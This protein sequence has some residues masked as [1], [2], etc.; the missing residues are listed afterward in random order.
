MLSDR[1]ILSAALLTIGYVF[2]LSHTTKQSLTITT[3]QLLRF[4]SYNGARIISL[5]GFCI[6]SSIVFSVYTSIKA[7]L[8]ST[9]TYQFDSIFYELDT[10]IH[11]GVKPWEITHKIFSHPL[12]TLFIN[13]L[14][15]L[16]FLLVFLG[17]IWIYLR[18]DSCR[19][20]FLAT[21]LMT[22]VVGGGVYAVLTASAGPCFINDLYEYEWYTELFNRLEQQSSWLTQNYDV[23]VWALNTQQLLWS[24][25]TS[26]DLSYGAGISAMP[27][28]HVATTTAITIATY[29]INKKVGWI[30]AAYLF[31]IL[32]GSV[33][34][35]W[36]YAIDGYASVILTIL[37][38]K[39]MGVV[40][41]NIAKRRKQGKC[42]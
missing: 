24:I 13:L 19:S 26:G 42:L 15:K 8:G 16:W 32:I 29:K 28:M 22:W 3:F 38:W 40:I 25:H 7:S 10:I 6:A 36:H 39:V 1:F 27:S 20:Q 21:Y 37:H 34:L 4:P 9:I 35:G 30:A 23:S 18:N 33:H 12:A 14:Y 2:W 41:N 11:F 5:L 17:Y 31:F